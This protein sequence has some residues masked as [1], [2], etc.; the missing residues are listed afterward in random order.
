MRLV[1]LNEHQE[2]TAHPPFDAPS[3]SR[4]AAD[5]RLP[6]QAMACERLARGM[7]LSLIRLRLFSILGVTI[8]PGKPCTLDMIKPCGITVVKCSS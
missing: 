1:I 6:Y 5:D 4:V 2:K 3:F 8:L 7:T